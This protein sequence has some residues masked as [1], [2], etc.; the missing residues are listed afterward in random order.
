MKFHHK[1]LLPLAVTILLITCMVVHAQDNAQKFKLKEGATGKLCMKCHASFSDKLKKSFVHTPLKKGDCTGCHNP[2]SSSHGKLLAADNKQICSSCHGAIIP[3]S[4]MSTH[5][6]VVEGECMKCH[7]PHSSMSKDNLLKPGNELC[8]DCHKE[9]GE[10]LGKVK[11]KHNPVEKGCLNC[12]EAHASSKGELLLK[13]SVAVLCIGC[14]KTDRP[15]FIKKHMNYPVAS[16]RCT[17]CHD[18]HG[19]NMPGILYDNVHKP[20]LSRMCNQCHDESSSPS[21]LKIKREGNELCKGCHSTFYNQIFD[22]N[23]VHWPLLDKQGC[24]S[25]HNPHAS[26]EKGLLKAPMLTLCGK[27]HPDT[28][29]RQAKSLTKHEPVMKGDCASCHDPH[30]SDSVQLYKQASVVDLC[31]TCHDWMK[32]S[33]H[34]IGDKFRDPRNKNLSVDCLSCHRSHGTEFK[35]MMPYATPSELCVQCHEKFRR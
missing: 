11:N 17:G 27:C 35:M 20:I 5:K 8:F 10:R 6:V 33:S 18:P 1:I 30:S 9:M 14:H 34:P 7:D 3:S 15:N 23:R 19:S 21:P 29:Q 2:H 13:N 16:A 32:H 25:C 24:L 22:K 12:H 4:T 31:A 26:A 28:I